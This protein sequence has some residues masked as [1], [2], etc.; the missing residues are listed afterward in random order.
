MI[1][2]RSRKRKETLAIRGKQRLN[3]HRCAAGF[4]LVCRCACISLRVSL[5]K[6]IRVSWFGPRDFERVGTGVQ[7]YLGLGLG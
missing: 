5:T 1:H 3:E 6:E 4:V 2:N 7:Y